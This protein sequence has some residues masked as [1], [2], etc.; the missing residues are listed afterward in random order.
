LAVQARNDSAPFSV[1]VFN[2]AVPKW[3]RREI[4]H[5]IKKTFADH[6]EGKDSQKETDSILKAAEEL[7]EAIENKFIEKTCN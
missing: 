6:F 7:A 5:F 3:H 2:E 4:V 1:Y